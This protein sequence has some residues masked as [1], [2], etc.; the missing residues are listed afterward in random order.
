MKESLGVKNLCQTNLFHLTGWP[1]WRIECHISRRLHVAGLYAIPENRIRNSRITMSRVVKG[2]SKLNETS[3]SLGMGI[4]QKNL[5]LS[6]NVLTHLAQKDED[7]GLMMCHECM[8]MDALFQSSKFLMASP[9][10]A[11]G[12]EILFQATLAPNFC[13]EGP[14]HKNLL[15][16]DLMSFN[17]AAGRIKWADQYEWIAWMTDIINCRRPE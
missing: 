3:Q 10:S 7:E 16:E 13:I 14:F 1:T 6:W 4:H 17:T 15:I 11:V 5:F 2:V 9:P 12:S 8:R